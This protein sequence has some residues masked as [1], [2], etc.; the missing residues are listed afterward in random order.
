MA[1]VFK[2]HGDH[3]LVQLDSSPEVSSGGIHIPQVSREKPQFGTVVALGE[4]RFPHNGE[5]WPYPFREGTRVLV[6]IYAGKEFQ[7]NQ[8]LYPSGDILGWFPNVTVQTANVVKAKA[9]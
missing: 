4:R 2:P 3:V 9:A 7:D 5:I 1:E 8:R 6:N